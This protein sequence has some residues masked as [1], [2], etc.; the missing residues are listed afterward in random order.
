MAPAADGVA[1][2]GAA[3]SSA[4]EIARR[5]LEEIRR[6]QATLQRRDPKQAFRAMSD[7]R[8]IMASMA[9]ARQAE[10]A[11]PQAT[12]HSAPPAPEPEP[13]RPPPVTTEPPAEES[14]AV[15]VTRIQARWRG[16]A[17]RLA[18]TREIEAQE[19]ELE[20]EPEAAAAAHA[21]T[22]ASEAAETS[23]ENDEAAQFTAAAEAEATT[24]SAKKIQ[25]QWRGKVGRQEFVREL[26]AQVSTRRVGCTPPQLDFQ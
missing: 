24:A 14:R 25:A 6:V 10:G 12:P 7:A 5:E 23:Q 16:N 22:T 26:E 4:T 18:V 3:G 13:A 11:P 8:A 15:S 17:G 20:A 19:A 2:D 21:A 9:A 1:A